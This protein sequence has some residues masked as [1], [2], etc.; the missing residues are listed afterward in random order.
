MFSIIS[1]FIFNRNKRFKLYEAS[2]YMYFKTDAEESFERQIVKINKKIKEEGRD[3]LILNEGEW[4][5]LNPDIVS[6]ICQ[7]YEIYE[8]DEKFFFRYK[9]TD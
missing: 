6:Y 3:K 7:D 4:Y 1:L 9:L 8:N 2:Q 5:F